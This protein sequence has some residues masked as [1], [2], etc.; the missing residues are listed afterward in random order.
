MNRFLFIA[1]GLVA[2]VVVLALAHFYLPKPISAARGQWQIEDWYV[3]PNATREQLE[4]FRDA[5]KRYPQAINIGSLGRGSIDSTQNCSWTESLS[6]QLELPA[7][8]TVWVTSL[9]C[10]DRIPIKL[11]IRPFTSALTLPG[12]LSYYLDSNDGEMTVTFRHGDGVALIDYVPAHW[13]RPAIE[14]LLGEQSQTTVVHVYR[15]HFEIGDRPFKSIEELREAAQGLD[16][17][18]SVRDCAAR[19]QLHD[20][21]SLFS[22]RT[23]D[24]LV[25]INVDEFPL[26]CEQGQP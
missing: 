23:R 20:L 2:I 26:R 7:L 12:V 9:E 14:D 22:D 19:E 15:D 24:G 11:I 18:L 13:P 16:I 25:S 1:S 17:S 8:P 5:R 10:E 3:H 21:L 4:Q 6:Q